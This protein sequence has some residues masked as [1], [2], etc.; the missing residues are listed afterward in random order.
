[1]DQTKREELEKTCK[2]EKDCRVRARMLAV[3]MVCVHKTS[4]WLKAKVC[5]DEKYDSNK[6]QISRS[7]VGYTLNLEPL[8]KIVVS[9]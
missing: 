1:M 4:I 2:K 6:K 8:V 5:A 7:H 9:R 3:H